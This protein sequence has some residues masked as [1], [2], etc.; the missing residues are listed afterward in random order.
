MKKFMFVLMIMLGFMLVACTTDS[1]DPID[2]PDDPVVT[3]TVAP[4]LMGVNDVSIELGTAFDET[5]GVT[6]QDDVD[7]DITANI[8]I[9]GTVDTNTVGTY[10]LTYT[11]S[12]AAGNE[13]EQDRE[14]EVY[15]NEDGFVIPNGDFSEDE[16][17]AHTEPWTDMWVHK[18]S[19]SGAYNIDIVDGHVE[20]ELL[21]LGTVAHGMQFFVYDRVV[22]KDTIY[23]VTFDAKADLP[24]DIMLILEDPAAN[25]TRHFDQT[26][27]LTTDW[28]TYTTEFE[29]TADSIET[30]KFGFFAGLVSENS[31]LTTVYLDNVTVTA[32]DAFGD[33]TNPTITGVE[34]FTVEINSDFDPME[35]VNVVD[36][37]DQTLTVA[38]ITVE[39]TVDTTTL[40]DY[41]LTYTVTDET[42]NKTV[43]YR[44]IRVADPLP[45][46]VF[47]VANGD[48]SE[49]VLNANTQPWTDEW[50]HK[51]SGSGAYNIDIVDGHVEIE[52]T[53]LGTVPHGM[54]FFQYDRALN[55]GDF[56]RIT[57]DAKADIARDIKVV[58]EDPSNGYYRHLDVDVDIT[59]D[60]DTYTIE[61]LMKGE[62]ITT[63]K[64]G[65]FVGNVS[66]KSALTTIYLDNIAIKAIYPPID[67]EAPMIT[68]FS[69]VYSMEQGQAFD[70]LAGLGV[71]DNQDIDLT[72]D[73][74]VVTGT[75]DTN[76]AGVYSLAYTVTDSAGNVSEVYERE[77]RVYEFTYQDAG[78]IENGDF[79]AEDL[80][81]GG[82][83]SPWYTWYAS[84]EG[85]SVTYEINDNEQLEVTTENVGSATWAIQF[86]RQ[87][88]HL[89]LGKT[90]KISFDAM[91]T[92]P[93]EIKSFIKNTKVNGI[94]I[95]ELTDTMET[96]EILFTY[97]EA[98]TDEAYLGFEFGKF[99]E[100]TPANA[101]VTLDNIQLLEVVQDSILTNGDFSNGAWDAWWGDQW[102][103]V[104]EGNVTV[105]DNVIAVEVNTVGT[106]SYSPQIVEDGLTVPG[107]TAYRIE[108]DIKSD[109]ARQIR[110]N[111]GEGLDAEPW[112]LAFMDAVD[113]DTTTEWTHV[114]I[115]MDM[116][117]ETNENGKLVFEFGTINDEGVATTIYMRDIIVYPDYN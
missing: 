11:V 29:F 22:T 116:A 79:S 103:G 13:T 73:D 75:V 69:E 8:V 2:D 97:T 1:A 98:T 31:V 64:F 95:V 85:A 87:N 27:D 41:T 16:L 70:P 88:I 92:V 106:A 14:V 39:G 25:W 71:T 60:W 33:V 37:M 83:N 109:V 12:D 46:S 43:E 9:T 23:R 42:G 35:N 6:A 61:F 78:Q 17:N 89:E 80:E 19:G 62:D 99:S 45:E 20:I 44:V 55:Q 28:A 110:V 59:T 102:S 63:G 10:T 105:T 67:N 3:D 40:G 115:E 32:V 93:R 5:Q 68:G 38:D 104:S 76:N 100:A 91:S 34:D 96:Y 50:I 101:V 51:N 4:L 94:T 84:Y 56:Y 52:V 36:D 7:G 30:G 113:I 58:V 54:Q 53:N 21:D 107:H 114:V 18:N 86:K 15:E 24:R 49:D 47:Q 81:V 66:E 65:F 26:F 72:A 74:I 108:F 77:V 112:F 57:F 117:L 90:Y 111:F 48:F 82:E